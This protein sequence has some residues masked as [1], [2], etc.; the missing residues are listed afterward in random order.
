[1]FTNSAAKGGAVRYYECLNH[2][3]RKSQCPVQRINAS[4]LHASV[5]REIRRVA[6]HPT[7]MHRRIAEAGGWQSAGEAQ[8]SLRGQLSKQKQ[9]M[10]M[11]AANYIK[12][13]GEGRSSTYLLDAL[14]KVEAEKQAV[15][16]QLAQVEQEIEV[17]TVKRPTA[18]QVQEVWSEMLALWDEGTEE[19]RQELTAAFVTW[20]E[21][22]EKDRASMELM[23][24]PTGY[25]QK[26]VTKSQ[27]GA[28]AGLEPATFGL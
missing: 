24:T 4:A 12:A 6:T 28:G 7:V 9:M 3:K 18:A 22:K 19:E 17:A 13:I 11:R 20:V 10:D 23:A 25:G 1:M 14:E 5:L 21:V 27:M 26:F 2:A 16:E 8:V 15:C